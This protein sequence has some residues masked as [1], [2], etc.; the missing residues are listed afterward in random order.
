MNRRTVHHVCSLGPLCHSSELLKVAELKK[1]SYPFDWIF[2][3]YDMVIHCIEDNFKIFMDK[4]YYIDIKSDK[5]GHKYYH[6]ELFNHRN[7][8]RVE[9]DYA[10]YERCISRFQNL[11]RCKDQHKLFLLINVNMTDVTDADTNAAITFNKEFSKYTTNY[12]LLVVFNVINKSDNYYK[13][14]RYGNIDFLE[15]HTLTSS[16]GVRFISDGDN[17]YLKNVILN[18][19]N[20]SFE[21]V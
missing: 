3:S 5:C 1:C 18:N 11:L 19:C 7:P 6:E 16:R 17:E 2:S 12:T 13:H 21:I 10:Y 15:L 4:S 20:Y 8:L 14:T 9:T